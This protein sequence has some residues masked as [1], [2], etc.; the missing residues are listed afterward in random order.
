MGSASEQ[1]DIMLLFLLLPA[2][3]AAPNCYQLPTA[4]TF[5]GEAAIRC[6]LRLS[7]VADAVPVAAAAAAATHLQ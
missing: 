3:A 7:T 4:A 2:A 6:Q 1:R 5:T